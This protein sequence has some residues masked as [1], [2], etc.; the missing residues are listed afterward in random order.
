MARGTED[1]S[2]RVPRARLAR[3]LVAVFLASMLVA[4]KLLPTCFAARFNWGATD[5]IHSLISA[6]TRLA[7]GH[8]AGCTGP[9][10]ALQL[11]LML[12]AVESLE[13]GI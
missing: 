7:F 4:V 1:Y 13:A 9:F 6:E 2:G 5:D 11:A 3:T 12:A 8:G 10:V